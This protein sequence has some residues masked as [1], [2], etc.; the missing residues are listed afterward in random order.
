MRH[1]ADRKARYCY[2]GRRENRATIADYGQTLDFGGRAFLR[3]RQDIISRK[4][5]CYQ[6]DTDYG[7]RQVMSDDGT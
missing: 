3:L 1:H 4:S 2:V 6:N 5:Q 7:G